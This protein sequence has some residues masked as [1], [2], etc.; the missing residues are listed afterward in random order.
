MSIFD[1]YSDRHAHEYRD[2]LHR[3]VVPG[4]VTATSPEPI[5]STRPLTD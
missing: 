3:L 4:F 5:S 2:F 1:V